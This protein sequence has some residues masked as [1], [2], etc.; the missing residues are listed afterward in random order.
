LPE[1][2]DVPTE[3]ASTDRKESVESKEV[4]E[5]K[6]SKE[7]KELL[8]DLVS[9]NRGMF[10]RRTQTNTRRPSLMIETSPVGNTPTETART[11]TPALPVD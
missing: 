9:S 11:D 6:E 1:L 5:S 10:P 4:K 7:F 3:K 8:N 2:E